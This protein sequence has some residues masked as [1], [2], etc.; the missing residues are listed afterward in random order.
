MT[1]SINASTTGGIVLTSD[2]SGTLDI[3]SGGTTK[4]TVATGGVTATVATLNAPSGVLA[5]QN[6]MTGIAKAWVTWNGSAGTGSI[7]KSFNV[8]SVTYTT[9]GQWVINFTTAMPDA[10]YSM[11]ASAGRSPTY[12]NTGGVFVSYNWDGT[13]GTAPTT[14]ACAVNTVQGT[15]NGADGAYYNPYIIACVFFD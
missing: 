14:T 9:T 11:A 2:T 7:S 1:A 15:R 8:S 3:Q 10:N 6:G 5:T 4:L 13:N 12:P